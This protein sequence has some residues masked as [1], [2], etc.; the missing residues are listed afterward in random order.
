MKI[1]QVIACIVMIKASFTLLNVSF[2]EFSEW[3]VSLVQK[4]KKLTLNEKIIKVQ[5]KK[6]D[7][8]IKIILNEAQ[9]ILNATNKGSKFSNLCVLSLVLLIGGVMFAISIENYFLV[10]V[11]AVGFA[12]V[13]FWYVFFIS[14]KWNKQIA[15][16]LE[17]ALSVITTSYMRSE[18]IITSIQ[19]NIEYLN[20]PI[21]EV[22][23]RFLMETRLISS[24]RKMALEKLKSQIDNEVFKEW[25]DQV[26]QCQDNRNLKSALLPI[27]HK[28]NSTKLINSELEV[29]MYEPIKEVGLIAVFTVLS[30]PAIY[31]VNKDWFN[32]LV[33]HPLGKSML[34]INMLVVFISIGAA[35]ALTKPIQAQSGIK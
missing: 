16:E 32:I 8:G 13:P 27:V 4:E 30:I 3:V 12:L 35:V 26:I 10:P 11:L 19:E 6:K 18:N 1:L 20:Y 9:E 23:T 25:V 2:T 29:M 28:L 22:F 15:N 7:T 31:F 34:A 33:H 14:N 21:K 5:K 17:T 24:N